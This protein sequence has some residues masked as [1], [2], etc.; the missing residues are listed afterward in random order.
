MSSKDNEKLAA[1]EAAEICSYLNPN[2]RKFA[3]MVWDLN[4]DMGCGIAECKVGKAKQYSVACQYG[5]GVGKY[6]NTIYMMG[7]TCNRCGGP[8]KCTDGA[9]CP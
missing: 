8:A 7:P 2:I 3:R 6:G 9:F 5:Q 4:A 1:I